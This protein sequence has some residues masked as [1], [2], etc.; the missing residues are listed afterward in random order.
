MMHVIAITTR[1][2]KNL[3]CPFI[4]LPFV[5]PVQADAAKWVRLRVVHLKRK[6]KVITV[7]LDLQ[8][9]PTTYFER[10]TTTGLWRRS[11]I[12]GVL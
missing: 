1:Y 6:P 2:N 11:V 3:N 5:G 12:Q 10:D 9:W 7:K 4:A 8:Y